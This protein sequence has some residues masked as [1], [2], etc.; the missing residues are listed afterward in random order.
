M[1]ED[2][3]KDKFPTS[4]RPVFKGL[5]LLFLVIIGF[6]AVVYLLSEHPEVKKEESKNKQAIQ[7]FSPEDA[8][9]DD[10]FETESVQAE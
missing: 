2:W 1:Q 4:A 8:A 5:G 3:D 6:C 10:S 9:D 7:D